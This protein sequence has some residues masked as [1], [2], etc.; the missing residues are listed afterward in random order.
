MIDFKNDRYSF[1]SSKRVG[2]FQI[3]LTTLVVGR[4]FLMSAQMCKLKC[5]HFL[6]LKR[7]EL[8][9]APDE[10]ILTSNLVELL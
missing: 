10:N 3:R 1:K 2:R 4:L 7:F 8:K 5:V 6:V 9:C